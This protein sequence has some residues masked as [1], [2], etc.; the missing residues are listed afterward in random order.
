MDT[1]T[2]ANRALKKIQN[3]MLDDH[4]LKLSLAQKQT[5]IG[6]QVLKENKD[7]LLKKRKG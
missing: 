5:S 1:A 4:A 3:F 7:K 2:A 6:D